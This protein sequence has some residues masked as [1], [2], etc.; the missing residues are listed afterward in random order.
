MLHVENSEQQMKSCDLYFYGGMIKTARTVLGW[1]SWQ[2]V[3]VG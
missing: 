3:Q 1:V 2:D